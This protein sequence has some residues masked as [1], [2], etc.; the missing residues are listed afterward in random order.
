MYCLIPFRPGGR[1]SR[2]I[3]IYQHRL[4]KHRY[5][6]YYNSMYVYLCRLSR[7][8]RIL[9]ENQPPG[10]NGMK[11]F[12][13]HLRFISGT[14]PSGN[15]CPENIKVYTGRNWYIQVLVVHTSMD[16][17]RRYILIYTSIYLYVPVYTSSY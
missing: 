3:L 13:L 5:D 10:R 1:L 2:G 11:Q 14:E 8:M 16:M 12:I 4:L 7:Y 15:S 9:L 6:M 17:I